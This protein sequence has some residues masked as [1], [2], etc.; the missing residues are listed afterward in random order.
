MLVVD[1]NPSGAH[2]GI[3]R[4]TASDW[5]TPHLFAL[6]QGVYTVS[7]IQSGYKIWT[8]QVDLV[9]TREKWLMADFQGSPQVNKGILIVETD[10]PGMQVWVDDKM[11]RGNRIQAVLPAG[12]HAFKVMPG[13][14]SQPYA[15]NFYLSS[16]EAVTK[17]V[18]VTSSSAPPGYDVRL[19]SFESP[20]PL[21]D[22]RS[23]NP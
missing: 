9:G 1:S 22:S 10:P 14:D 21:P 16:G 12:W 7:V 8:R 4:R 6:T 11:Y 15:T 19:E 2:I 17:R 3:N 23:G 18:R 5:V 20:P 13:P